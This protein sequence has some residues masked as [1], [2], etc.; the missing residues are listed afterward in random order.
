MYLGFTVDFNCNLKSVPKID[1]FPLFNPKIF[2][3]SLIEMVRTHTS[4][5]SE[6]LL[7]YIFLEPM[8]EYCRLNDC[9]SAI[10][11]LKLYFNLTLPCM[12]CLE[13]SLLDKYQYRM[14]EKC[15]IFRPHNRKKKWICFCHIHT[16]LRTIYLYMN[17]KKLF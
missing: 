2:W 5:W 12:S 14:L 10:G 7:V 11:I 1:V 15:L 13:F 16:F 4:K 6:Y 3:M 9:E 17:L 8:V